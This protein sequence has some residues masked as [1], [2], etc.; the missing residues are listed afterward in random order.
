MAKANNLD[1]ELVDTVPATAP[2]EYLKLNKLGKVPTFVAA[3]GSVLIE[4][5]A[6]YIYGMLASSGSCALCLCF[7]FFSAL[8]LFSFAFS[9]F[10]RFLG[11]RPHRDDGRF[12]DELDI[13]L[14]LSLSE[15]FC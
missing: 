13:L 9:P 6:I 2:P 7:P 5:I 12:H 1:I 11:I 15:S 14:Q 10:P 8:S 4:C 3:D